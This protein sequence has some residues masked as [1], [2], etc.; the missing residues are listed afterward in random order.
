MPPLYIIIFHLYVLPICNNVVGQKNT[1]L[2][3]F[4]LPV[5][6][7]KTLTTPKWVRTLLRPAWWA[8]QPWYGSP[9]IPAGKQ[10]L[11][12]REVL[13]GTAPARTPS[14]EESKILEEGIPDNNLQ[15]MIPITTGDHCCSWRTLP[16]SDWLETPQSSSKRSPEVVQR[17]NGCR[18]SMPERGERQL[19]CP[20]FLILVT[21]GLQEIP[22]SKSGTYCLGAS[23]VE[24]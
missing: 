16:Y 19:N 5:S 17:E 24:A 3:P 15:N 22:G 7:R 12:V 13:A 20:H 23:T 10:R 21:D 2:A 18:R 1:P 4:P 9:E 8:A 14:T 11:R 6:R